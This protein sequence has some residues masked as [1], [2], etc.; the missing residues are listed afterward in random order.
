MKMFNLNCPR[1]KKYFYGDIS[2]IKLKVPVHCPQCDGII[3][4]QEYSPCLNSS[5]GAALARLREP[6]TEE[7]MDRVL[8][9]PAG[10]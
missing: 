5:D 2:M 3:P 6:L 7:N 10:K 4:F 8:Y 1:C 9:I